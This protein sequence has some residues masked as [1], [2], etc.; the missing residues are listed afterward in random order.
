[1][2][3]E[4]NPSKYSNLVEVLRKEVN[5]GSSRK[6]ASCCKAFVWLTRLNSFLH[7]YYGLLRIDLEP[8]HIGREGS[9]WR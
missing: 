9:G 4:S 3:H 1:M 7:L 2:A 5:E 6:G 8:Q